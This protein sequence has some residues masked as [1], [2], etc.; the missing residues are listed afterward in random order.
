MERPFHVSLID[1]KNLP[2]LTDHLAKFDTPAALRLLLENEIF[3][4][5]FT[6]LAFGQLADWGCSEL[7]IDIWPMSSH[8]TAK[9]EEYLW[10]RPDFD[11]IGSYDVQNVPELKLRAIELFTQDHLEMCA[12]AYGEPCPGVHMAFV[13]LLE[14]LDLA[15][16]SPNHLILLWMP[17]EDFLSAESC[18]DSKV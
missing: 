4:G 8:Q 17:K 3:V 7:N 18:L 1:L 11:F 6:H 12:T 16:I 13:K 10:N 15:A 9:P 5:Q 14:L 2:E